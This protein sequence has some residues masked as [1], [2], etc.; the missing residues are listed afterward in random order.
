MPDPEVSSSTVARVVFYLKTLR[1]PP[2]RNPTGSEVAAGAA[3][4]TAIGCARCH[5]ST[6]T[7]GPSR[8]QALDRVTFH[9]YTDLLLHDMGPALDDH[10]TEGSA[11]TAEWRTAPLWGIG[12]A[13]KAQGGR[14]FYLH[15]GRA[16]TIE[17]AVELHGGE[18]AASRAAFRTLPAGDVQR[19][20]AF[21]RS[22]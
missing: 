20:L 7:T 19:L 4:F 5:L 15:D 6:L 10:Y 21:L 1:P 11:T 13:E 17:Q 9:P 14:A 22:L 16:T 18:A 3:V 12:L 2:R 8:L